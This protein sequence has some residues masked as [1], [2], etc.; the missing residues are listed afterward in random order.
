MSIGKLLYVVVFS[1]ILLY[2]GADSM[3]QI[4]L[5]IYM[6]CWVLKM[7]MLV[8]R[9]Q[10]CAMYTQYVNKSALSVLRS[11]VSLCT[12]GVNGLKFTDSNISWCTSINSTF[13]GRFFNL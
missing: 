5:T 8:A 2:Q 11:D 1:R 9:I 10:R 3:Y 6:C 7:P 4:H 12:I 13:Y